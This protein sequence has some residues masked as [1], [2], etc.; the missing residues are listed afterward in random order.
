MATTLPTC[1]HR[2]V[3]GWSI[4]EESRHIF[5]RRMRATPDAPIE[6]EFETPAVVRG[7]VTDATYL[8]H[9]TGATI[10]HSWNE[11][12]QRWG[13]WAALELQLINPRTNQ[14][15]KTGWKAERIAPSRA[16]AAVSN[17]DD[18]LQP[19]IHA[20]RPRTVITVTEISVE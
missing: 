9:V 8:A 3:D 7:I 13:S 18:I 11:K 14:P 10:E 19:L 4:T 16:Y 2:A 1:T 20:S 6:V 12:E 15:Y 5:M 17:A